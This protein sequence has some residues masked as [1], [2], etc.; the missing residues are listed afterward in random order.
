MGVF[1]A[2]LC[3]TLLLAQVSPTA[4]K[5]PAPAVPQVPPPAAQAAPSGTLQEQLEALQKE[6]ADARAAF[7]TKYEAAKTDL[8]KQK[9]FEAEYPKADTY[10]PR[11]FDLAERAKGQP[12]ALESLVWILRQRPKADVSEKVY[13]T[14]LADHGHAE[15]LADVVRTI[16]K[17][18]VD[19]NA[20]G[21][22]RDVLATSPHESVKGHATFALASLLCGYARLIEQSAGDAERRKSLESAYGAEFI[23]SLAARDVASVQTEAEKLLETVVEE[24][25]GVETTRGTLG[26]QATAQLFEIR[27]LQIGKEAP[28]IEGE[29]VDGV[30]F[31]L[32]DYRGK[33]V[34][35]DFWGIW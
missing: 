35:I 19:P 31:K 2:P 9:L 1:V 27:S 26:A 18:T 3:I 21:F 4:P 25:A 32:S 5:P 10:F 29:D 15:A 14:A 20:E 8:E 28:E 24:Y 17:Y 22:L 16:N 13:T 33:V 6:F 34:V 7:M 11:F 12:E 30:N 23:A